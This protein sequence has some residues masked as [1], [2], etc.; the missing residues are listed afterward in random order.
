MAEQD[1][2]DRPDLSMRVDDHEGRI[3][4]LERGYRDLGDEY[5]DLRRE[6]QQTSAGLAALSAKTDLHADYQERRATRDAQDSR[7]AMADLE[8]RV[9][10]EIDKKTEPFA[11]L[12]EVAQQ[13]RGAVRLLQWLGLGFVGLIGTFVGWQAFGQWVLRLLGGH[14]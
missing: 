8:A 5:G 9:V 12:L 2:L 4:T 13:I 11:Q 14:A 1:V 3:E 6:I 10:G 7:Q